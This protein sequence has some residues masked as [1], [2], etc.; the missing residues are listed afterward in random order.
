MHTIQS[1]EFGTIHVRTLPLPEGF[2]QGAKPGFTTYTPSGRV[3]MQYHLPEDPENYIHIIS[4][5]D[6][7]TDACEI[8]A[9]D[10]T[11]I[12][13]SNGFRYMP[14]TDNQ[15]AYIGDWILECEPDCD[16]PVSSRLIPIRYPDELINTPG[17]W[18]VWS[19]NVVSP[20]GKTIAWSALG[21]TGSVYAAELR[22]EADCYELDNVRN[23]GSAMAYAEDPEHPGYVLQPKV[24]GGEVKQFV[25]GGLGLSFVGIGRGPGN[26]MYQALDSEDV[27]PLTLSPGYDETCMVSPDE[28]LGGV[29]STRFSPSTSSAILGLIPRRG[30]EETKSCLAMV[31]Y[32][33]GVS[34]V[35]SFRPKTNVGPALVDLNRSRTELSYQGVDLSD[36]E[37]RYVFCSPL[38][39]HP[40]GKKLMWNEC[41]RRSLGDDN[42]IRI[43]ELV[44]YEPGPMPETVPVPRKISYA[45]EGILTEPLIKQYPLKIAGLCSGTAITTLEMK[46]GQP[47]FT[48]TYDSFSDDGKTFLSGYETANNPGLTSMADNHYQADLTL[49]GAHKG[50]MEVTLGYHRSGFGGGVSLTEDSTGYASYDDVTLFVK[51]M[52]RS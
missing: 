26:S 23:V 2:P 30:N 49:T 24:R 1:A 22:R 33:Y 16:H 13:R 45:S 41:L 34:D 37:K 18:L 32:I 35:R 42:R 21:A 8:F 15:R 43:A 52:D 27:H 3:A 17:L 40:A 39:W 4:M 10:I 31:S 46:D 12:Y 28:R 5:E 19:E 25:R 11:P 48:T 14:F 36:P 51:D 7:G 20:D 29:M 38:S 47:I 9:G 6:D 50:R 44:D